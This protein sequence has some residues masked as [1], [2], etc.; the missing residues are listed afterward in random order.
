M[1]RFHRNKKKG[2]DSKDNR[3][4]IILV[5]AGVLLIAVLAGL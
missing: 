5:I 1:S 3:M 2:N 4:I